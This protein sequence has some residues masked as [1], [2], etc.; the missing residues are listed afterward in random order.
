MPNRRRSLAGSAPRTQLR[1]QGQPHARPCTPSAS[2]HPSSARF[3]PPDPFRS[4]NPCSRPFVLKIAQRWID[5]FVVSVNM[6]SWY[7][8]CGSVSWPRPSWPNH[9]GPLTRRVVKSGKKC[10]DGS[11]PRSQQ[12]P[13]AARTLSMPSR[14]AVRRRWPARIATPP[15]AAARFPPMAVVAMMCHPVYPPPCPLP[16]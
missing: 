14:N 9:S 8:S 16:R 4:S 5:F 7:E 2:C 13:L 3:W 15:L 6:T 10:R 1:Y 11:C 12:R